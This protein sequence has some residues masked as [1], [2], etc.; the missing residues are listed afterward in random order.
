MF[1]S[2]SSEESIKRFL[3]GGIRKKYVFRWREKGH[4]LSLQIRVPVGMVGEEK[5]ELMSAAG[6]GMT[7]H[8]KPSHACLSLDV[9]F[10]SLLFSLSASSQ[11]SY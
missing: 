4:F 9:E 1:S 7:R 10:L 3:K 5:I 8:L 2:R 11:H 6:C